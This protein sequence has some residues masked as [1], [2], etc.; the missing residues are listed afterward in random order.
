MKLLL[1]CLD[2]MR[3]VYFTRV[4]AQL[5][6]I[7]GIKQQPLSQLATNHVKMI[8][9]LGPQGTLVTGTKTKPVTVKSISETRV[10]NLCLRCL[11]E[12]AT[13]WGPSVSTGNG[14]LWYPL[15]CWHVCNRCSN[16]SLLL[17][18]QCLQRALINAYYIYVC[19][20]YSNLLPA[21]RLHLGS[22]ED[23]AKF[24]KIR[25]SI[26]IHKNPQFTCII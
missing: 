22:S 1:Q 26:Q 23:L 15:L 2:E 11:N 8:V 17:S 9:S 13:L 10:M 24:T 6:F 20:P 14:L 21:C 19:H 25:S 7:T 3:R 18:G 16:C 4:L 12:R 5:V